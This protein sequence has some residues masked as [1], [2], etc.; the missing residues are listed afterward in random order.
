MRGARGRSK[1]RAASPDG[2]VSAGRRAGHPGSRLPAL[3]CDERRRLDPDGQV[4]RALASRRD[5][6]RH[7]PKAR[8]QGFL[9]RQGAFPPPPVP[10]RAPRPAY[11]A[12]GR[13]LAHHL[14][15][16]LRLWAPQ[17]WART[18]RGPGEGAG[19][20]ALPPWAAAQDGATRGDLP[21]GTPA[22]NQPCR[23]VRRPTRGPVNERTGPLPRS[24]QSARVQHASLRPP[25]PDR[26]LPSPSAPAG[27]RDLPSRSRKDRGGVA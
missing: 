12:V 9:W 20:L 21:E 14:P 3:A 16:A 11:R 4:C 6:T 13:R 2:R 27:R 5:P 26:R 10:P 15:G 7:G 23:A 24:L 25:H 19:D 22:T 8:H 1:R 18:G 17:D